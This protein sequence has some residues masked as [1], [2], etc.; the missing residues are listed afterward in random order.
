VLDIALLSDCAV[1]ISSSRVALSANGGYTRA[2]ANLV[3]V[4]RHRQ[5]C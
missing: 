3:E 5:E 2:A 1:S 4:R